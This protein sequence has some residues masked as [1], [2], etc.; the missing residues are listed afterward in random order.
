MAETFEF[1][2]LTPEEL[3]AFNKGAEYILTLAH[4]YVNF[5]QKAYHDFILQSNPP[6]EQKLL[7]D[8]YLMGAEEFCRRLIDKLTGK[9]SEGQK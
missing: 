6:Q 4:R 1:D 9:A 3:A 8:G 7:N 2:K 5:L